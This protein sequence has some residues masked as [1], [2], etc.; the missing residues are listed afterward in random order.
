MDAVKRSRLEAKGWKFGDAA[1]FLELPEEER[2]L[3]E[4]RLKLAMAVRREREKNRISQQE[5]ARLMATSQPRV[6]K[7]EQAAPDVSLDQLVRAY[8]AVGGK[9]ELKLSKATAKELKKRE[10]PVQRKKRINAVK[11]MK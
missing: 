7:I 1:D 3:L 10:R 11:G 8:A 4:A 2:Q 6:V 5:L 9:V